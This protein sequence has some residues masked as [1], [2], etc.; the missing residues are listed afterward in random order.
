MDKGRVVKDVYKLLDNLTVEDTDR[1]SKYY[2]EQGLLY[3]EVEYM[4][5]EEKDGFFTHESLKELVNKRIVNVHNGEM[6][7]DNGVVAEFRQF[8]EELARYVNA[9][10]KAV[11][12]DISDASISMRDYMKTGNM[13]LLARVLIYCTETHSSGY[14]FFG[15]LHHATITMKK[16]EVIVK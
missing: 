10:A 8:S 11:I 3:K 7:L 15:D 12:I 2:E 1:L 4:Y 5:T 14:G 9:G 16:R 13:E 6:I